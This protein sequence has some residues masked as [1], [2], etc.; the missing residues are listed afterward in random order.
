VLTTIKNNRKMKLTPYLHFSG[1]AEE[2]LNFYVS[3]LDGKIEMLS[4]YGDSPMPCDEDWKPKIMHARLFFGDNNMIMISDAFKGGE[5]RTEGNVQ[6]SI[7]T[8]DAEA[9]EVI[10]NKM[11]EGGT[12]T[13]P[14]QPQF[15][16]AIFG[17]LKDKFGVSWMFNCEMKK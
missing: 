5:V 1:N 9:M 8:D 2:A 16:G 7:G 12:V 15:W 4:R 17:M 10:F 13:M 6:L 11:A 3:S 14:L